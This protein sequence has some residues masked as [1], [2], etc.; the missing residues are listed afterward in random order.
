M[1]LSLSLFVETC[2]HG[3]M[4]D[5]QPLKTSKN[6]EERCTIPQPTCWPKISNLSRAKHQMLWQ[7]VHKTIAS[8]EYE[9]LAIV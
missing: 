5:Q 2:M 6:T 1:Y 8:N 9:S 7:I 4:P 3:K